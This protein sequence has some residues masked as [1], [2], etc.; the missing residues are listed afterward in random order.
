M[1]KITFW[2][3]IVF[4]FTYLLAGIGLDVYA[5]TAP[6]ASP[7]SAT[8]TDPIG[9]TSIPA[10]IGQVINVALGLVGS[11]ALLMFIYGGFIWM[12]SHGNPQ[13]VQ[14]GKQVLVWAT[15]GIITIFTSYTL[16]KFIMQNVIGLS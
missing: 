7:G 14:K 15:I 11:L 4:A 2:I 13:L 16:V 5:Q 12:L 1:G 3:L 9:V 10:L 6:K 8:L